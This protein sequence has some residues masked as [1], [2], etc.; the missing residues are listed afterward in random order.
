MDF[1]GWWILI[2]VVLETRSGIP[3]ENQESISDDELHPL[4]NWFTEKR[5]AVYYVKV[6]H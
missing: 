1:F 5:E 4:S 3:H 6:V 2:G